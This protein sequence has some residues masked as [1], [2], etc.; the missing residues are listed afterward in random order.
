MVERY[1]PVSDKANNS[2]KSRNKMT[3]HKKKKNKKSSF[4]KGKTTVIKHEISSD[5]DL[6]VGVD[7]NITIDEGV[8]KE[9]EE[10]NDD[11]DDDDDDEKASIGAESRTES[12]ASSVHIDSGDDE[13]LEEEEERAI[14]EEMMENE[15]ELDEVDGTDDQS[16]LE[17]DDD[18]D[19]DNSVE[20][21]YYVDEDED[22]DDE[23]AMHGYQFTVADPW[24]SSEDDDGE[25]GDDSSELYIEDDVESAISNEQ[26][27]SLLGDANLFDNI[28]AAFLQILA[29]LAESNGHD[30]NQ[31]SSPADVLGGGGELDLSGLDLSALTAELNAMQSSDFHRRPSLPSSAVSA[32]Q[33]HSAEDMT[34]E[35]LG[36]LSA[37]SSDGALSLSL[38]TIS[39][40]P[41]EVTESSSRP[42]AAAAAD[43]QSFSQAQQLLDLVQMATSRTTALDASN[44]SFSA[45]TTPTEQIHPFLALEQS[46]GSSQHQERQSSHGTNGDKRRG[47]APDVSTQEL[48][49]W[50]ILNNS[51]FL[52]VDLT[53]RQE[54]QV[55]H[56]TARQD[57]IVPFLLACRKRTNT[58]IHG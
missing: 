6:D 3:K 18:T 40:K 54:A 26:L 36:A 9:E 49:T 38:S 15:H 43:M 41:E 12:Y 42:N 21:Y 57:F 48:L 37:L 56:C 11:D 53:W 29:P 45:P 39:E 28:A 23:E 31:S 22:D 13:G 58:C 35:R 17:G 14:I 10:G 34:S 46:S 47:S 5:D 1:G 7:G 19:D 4:N 2:S 44:I 24:S 16:G 8:K 27:Q 52:I 51:I 55:I 50:V 33:N 25:D 20:E 30:G 32:A